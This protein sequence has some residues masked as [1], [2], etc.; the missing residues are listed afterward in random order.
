MT[1]VNACL[2]WLEAEI[3]LVKPGV[4]VCLGATAAQALFGSSF[5]VTAHRGESIT[6]EKWAKEILVTY[7]PSAILRLRAVNA[8]G[9]R[10]AGK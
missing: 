9:A 5:K 2:G 7:H 10:A 8:D 3:A 1:E 6:G 4:I